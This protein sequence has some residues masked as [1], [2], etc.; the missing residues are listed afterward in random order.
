[1]VAREG[2]GVG[3]EVGVADDGEGGFVVGAG[4]GDDS[5]GEFEAALHG[6]DL[7]VG[8][9]GLVEGV[10]DGGAEAGVGEFSGEGTGAVVADECA[11]AV[12]KRVRRK[13]ANISAKYPCIPKSG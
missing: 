11:E 3:G 4:G 5:G 9:G 10:G 8:V 12:L 2:G 13:R 7:G 1:M 6:A